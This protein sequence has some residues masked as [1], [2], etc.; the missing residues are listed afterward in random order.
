MLKA[1]RRYSFPHFFLLLFS[2]FLPL[3]TRLLRTGS[4][5]LTHTLRTR[6]QPLNHQPGPPFPIRPAETLRR[7][8]IGEKE[9]EKKKKKANQVLLVKGV[10]ANT[11]QQQRSCCA[12]KGDGLKGKKEKQK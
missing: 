3:S 5:R 7:N 6:Q 1:P 12:E 9:K 10:K 11:Q 2:F 8:D 4:I